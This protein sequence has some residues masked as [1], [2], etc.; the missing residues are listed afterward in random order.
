MSK[1]NKVVLAYHINISIFA[2]LC[3]CIYFVYV[4]SSQSHV[5]K[6]TLGVEEEII[7]SSASSTLVQ[8]LNNKGFI[9]I[10]NEKN[11]GVNVYIKNAKGR[12]KAIITTVHGKFEVDIYTMRDY[13]LDLGITPKDNGEYPKV[14]C[15]SIG[16]FSSGGI[17]VET[18]QQNGVDVYA[19]R[20]YIKGD[21]I[22]DS[23]FYKKIGIK[24]E[25]VYFDNVMVI[26][27]RL[28][29]K[30]KDII[31]IYDDEKNELI[32]SYSRENSEIT[33]DNL[34]YYTC[35]AVGK[36]FI[37]FSSRYYDNVTEFFIDCKDSDKK[38]QSVYDYITEEDYDLNKLMHNE[39]VTRG[40]TLTF[41]T[42]SNGKLI[43]DIN[44]IVNKT[45]EKQIV[46]P[47]AK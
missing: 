42:R 32:F 18:T 17:V 43:Y 8:R 1:H 44:D 14:V 6:G 9:D 21:K 34:D 2:S 11:S 38:L 25:T 12:Q 27:N 5:L 16:R 39:S 37:A 19:N 3:I 10:T 26:L 47:I 28:G 36:D 46:I 4:Y 20:I 33:F 7:V 15:T 22:I 31:R 13:D 23:G 40:H 41:N 30:S 29:G 24:E 35:E 45:M